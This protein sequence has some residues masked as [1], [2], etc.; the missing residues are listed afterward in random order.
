M[1]Q[2]QNFGSRPPDATSSF[3]TLLP[4]PI[5]IPKGT[6]RI[7]VRLISSVLGLVASITPAVFAVEVWDA[8]PA[9]LG[10]I[11]PGYAL[12]D[13]GGGVQVKLEGWLD[14]ED[15]STIGGPVPTFP[16][17]STVRMTTNAPIATGVFS[18]SVWFFA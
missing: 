15:P 4:P 13:A 3:I 16:P 2:R 7:F 6:Q 12:A 10:P 5:L 14:S 18:I 8:T 9:F 17:G 11:V 1:I